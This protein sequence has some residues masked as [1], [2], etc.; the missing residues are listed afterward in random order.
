METLSILR[1]F[2]IFYGHLLHFE[3]I[4]YISPVLEYFTKK[5]LA[6]LFPQPLQDVTSSFCSRAQKNS[7]LAFYFLVLLAKFKTW[8][9]CDVIILLTGAKKF[10]TRILFFGFIG[11]IQNLG[12]ML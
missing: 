8:D 2:Y 5:N 7:T 1:P 12:P 10:D 4:W 9:R 11:E 6:T 3:V